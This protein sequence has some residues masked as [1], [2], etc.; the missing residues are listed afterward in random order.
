MET[1]SGVNHL[2]GQIT[3]ANRTIILLFSWHETSRWCSFKEV[4]DHSYKFRSGTGRNARN[5]S[6]QPVDRYEKGCI[7]YQLWFRSIP[8]IPAVPDE[9]RRS[10]DPVPVGW[11]LRAL[12]WAARHA[13]RRSPGHEIPKTEYRTESKKTKP[14]V[15]KPKFSVPYSVPN[16][17]EPNLP[18]Y[19]RFFTSVYRIYRIHRNVLIL[20]VVMLM[21]VLL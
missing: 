6:Y 2:R 19:I 12:T 20:S 18:R 9:I 17:Q 5:T 4:S 11:S 7:P 10:T 13:C 1:D 3:Q 15:P 14:K 21:I 8:A 16:S